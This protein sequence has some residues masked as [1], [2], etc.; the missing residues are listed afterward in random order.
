MKRQFTFEEFVEP[1]TKLKREDFF[2]YPANAYQT[3]Y[4]V[5]RTVCKDHRKRVYLD[6]AI[7][8]TERIFIRQE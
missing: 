4:R 5:K 6:Q 8:K 3:V 7:S 2:I 1:V